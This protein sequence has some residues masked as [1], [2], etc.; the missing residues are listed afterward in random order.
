MKDQ[1]CRLVVE[2][3]IGGL[4]EYPWMATHGL[5]ESMRQMLAAMV[6]PKEHIVI[7]QM[8]VECA[9]SYIV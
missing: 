5:A 8:Y 2:S 1:M 6:A 9:V 4:V 7:I 3:N